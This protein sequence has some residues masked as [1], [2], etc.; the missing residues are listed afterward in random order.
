MVVCGVWWP[1]GGWGGG[2]GGVGGAGRCQLLHPILGGGRFMHLSVHF[3]SSF[4]VKSFGDGKHHVEIIL[5][6]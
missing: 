2:G 4:Y 5:R 6:D 3:F 1:E